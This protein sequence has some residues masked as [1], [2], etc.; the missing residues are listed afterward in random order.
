[1]IKRNLHRGL[2][3]LL[4]IASVLS[5]LYLNVATQQFTPAYEKGGDNQEK[6]MVIDE[7]EDSKK[8]SSIALPNVR[9][10]KNLAT[11]GK[12]VLPGH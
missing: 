4:V 3:V 11:L 6:S 12:R 1:M 9:L 8:N 2:L 5:F 7:L 10:L